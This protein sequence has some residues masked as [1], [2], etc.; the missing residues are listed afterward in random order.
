ML[1]WLWVI[2]CKVG[3]NLW[4]WEGY[5]MSKP[6]QLLYLQTWFSESLQ[7]SDLGPYI[8]LTQQF[9]WHRIAENHN[10]DHPR[11]GKCT[12][13]YTLLKR[14]LRKAQKWRRLLRRGRGGW[15]RGT[16]LTYKNC[17]Q[18]AECTRPISQERKPGKG[19]RRRGVGIHQQQWRRWCQ[20]VRRPAANR[21][22]IQSRGVAS[23]PTASQPDGRR[24]NQ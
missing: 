21:C 19:R 10:K 9:F 1:L 3:G 15:N 4:R 8:I 24:E 12:D 20:W 22:Q 5:I 16:I 6:Q 2:I 13:T 7:S 18:L 11:I 17:H 14:E 23:K